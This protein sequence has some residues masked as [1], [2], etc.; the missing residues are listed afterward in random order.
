MKIHILLASVIVSYS[1]IIYAQLPS[2]AIV[3]PIQMGAYMP[4]IINPRDYA[5]PETS[6]LIAMDYNIFF[7]S[8]EY[9]DRHGNKVDNLD[10]GIGFDP[11]P[12]EVDMS[13]YLNALAIVYVSPELSFFGKARYLAFISPYYSTMDYRVALSELI[14]GDTAVTGSTGGFGDLS[15]APIYLTWAG[16]NQKWDVTAGY[17][18][19]APTGRYETGADDN[20]GLGYWNHILQVFAYY[21]PLPEKATAIF[22]GN[23]F[24]F[25]SKIKDAD[26]RP[27]NRYTIDYGISQYLSERFEITI[28]GGNTW[29]IREDSGDDVYWDTSFKDRYSTIGVGLGFWP[30]K[31]KF[32]T[33]LKWWTNY[34]IRQH[35]K[36]NNIQ[37]QLIYIPGILMAKADKN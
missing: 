23:S 10:I 17:M 6:G 28:Q 7:D 25:H 24:E 32:Y 33:H 16:E 35:F 14:V 1:N 19:S 9:V 5:N 36:T 22:L 27:G 3:S 4:G 11:V 34:G 2:A 29:Q 18:F 20:I 30:V 21:Y 13:G 15:I 12:I 8:D 37:L 26:V 31:Q